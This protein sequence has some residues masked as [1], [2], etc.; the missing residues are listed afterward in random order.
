MFEMFDKV[1]TQKITP[2][3]IRNSAS[4]PIGHVLNRVDRHVL[5][6]HFDALECGI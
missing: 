5:L 6:H 1:R 3:N 2:K 4:Q